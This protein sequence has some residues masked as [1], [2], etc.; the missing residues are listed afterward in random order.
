MPQSHGA[1][2]G[3]STLLR[4]RGLAT[5]LSVILVLGLLAGGYLVIMDARAF[6]SAMLTEAARTNETL[7]QMQV[8][9]L[10]FQLQLDR[11]ERMLLEQQG[12]AP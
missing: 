1:L 10:E 11:I 3:L 6:Q 8:A 9:H 2:A 5:V 4:E 12:R 7:H